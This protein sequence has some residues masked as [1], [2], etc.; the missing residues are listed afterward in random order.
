MHGK[1]LTS[2]YGNRCCDLDSSITLFG[3]MGAGLGVPHNRQAHR[4]I[5]HKLRL[6]LGSSSM[7]P[8]VKN[9]QSIGDQCLKCKTTDAAGETIHLWL[10]ARKLWNLILQLG[11]IQAVLEYML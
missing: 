8:E 5:C 1:P 10:S 9:G 3:K 4:S 2:G 6:P 7:Y 11:S